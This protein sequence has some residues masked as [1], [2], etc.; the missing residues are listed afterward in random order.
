MDSGF[1]GLMQDPARFAEPS[2]V[3]YTIYDHVGIVRR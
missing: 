3:Y 1:G 2:G